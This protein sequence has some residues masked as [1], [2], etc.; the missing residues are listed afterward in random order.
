M[1]VTGRK[2]PLNSLVVVIGAADLSAFPAYEVVD[3]QQIIEELVGE[4]NRPDINYQVWNEIYRRVTVKLSMGE[5]VVVRANVYRKST[6]LSLTQ[7]AVKMALPVFYLIEETDDGEYRNNERDFTRGDG[8]AEV[9]L[10]STPY[11]VVEKYRGDILQRVV[12]TRNGIT[13][14]GDIHGCVA[15]LQQAL[16]WASSRNNIAII[17]GDLVDYGPNPIE[18]VDIVYRAVT[19]GN[20]L[21]VIGNHE[22]KIERWLIQSRQGDVR[23]K[24]SEGNRVTTDAISQLSPTDRERFEQRF[25]ALMNLSHNHWVAGDVLFTHGA[26]SPTMWDI[27]SSRLSGEDEHM[28]LFGQTIGSTSPPTRIYSWVDDIP[29]GHTVVVGHDIRSREKPHTETG[30][31][32]GKAIFTDCGSGKGGKSFAVDLV[33]DGGK[34]VVQNFIQN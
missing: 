9:I 26:A 13:A 4:A 22:R 12:N 21:M 15:P 16:E 29:A 34:L 27:T 18:C 25:R 11:M 8:V 10:T 6:R 3:F 31:Q 24:L 5:R 7:Y 2:I 1:I 30:A 19:R 17:L 14:V 33:V 28:A 23:V 32:S 20:A